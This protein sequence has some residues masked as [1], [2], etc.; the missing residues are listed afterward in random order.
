MNDGGSHN[1]GTFIAT[2]NFTI[3]EVELLRDAIFDKF[4]LEAKIE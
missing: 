2:Y 1:A 4:N 3:S